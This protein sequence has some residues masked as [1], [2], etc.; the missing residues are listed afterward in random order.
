MLKNNLLTNNFDVEES[1]NGKIKKWLR[2]NW[3]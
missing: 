1:V 2:W 3:L